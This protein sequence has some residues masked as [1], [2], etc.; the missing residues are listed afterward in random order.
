MTISVGLLQVIVVVAVAL[1]AVAPVTLLVFLV[2]DW[3]KGTLW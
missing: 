2:R 1:S 3:K